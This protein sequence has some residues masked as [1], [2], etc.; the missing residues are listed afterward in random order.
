MSAPVDFLSPDSKSLNF[1]RLV[2][3]DHPGINAAFGTPHWVI[4]SQQG[5]A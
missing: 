3:F 4:N 2:Q 5:A 1:H